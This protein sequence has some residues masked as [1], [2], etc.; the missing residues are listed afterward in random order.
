VTLVWTAYLIMA[1][2]DLVLVSI[3][4]R[5]DEVFS[6]I[7]GGSK[8][9]C[10]FGG[11][12]LFELEEILRALGEEFQCLQSRSVLPFIKTQQVTYIVRELEGVHWW[13]L[14]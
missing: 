12:L 2:S 1:L 4:R 11:L 5:T 13:H 3:G 8:M 6:M 10:D 7:N 14:G 9:A